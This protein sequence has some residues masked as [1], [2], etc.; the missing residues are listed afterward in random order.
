VTLDERDVC[1]GDGG[2]YDLADQ[3]LL[4]QWSPG[5]VDIDHHESQQLRHLK[6]IVDHDRG[7]EGW[8]ELITGATTRRR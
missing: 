5:L 1:D 7:R 3:V 4:G 2:G 6:V 8:I